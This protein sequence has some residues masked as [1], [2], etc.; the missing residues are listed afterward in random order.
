MS[1][2]LQCICCWWENKLRF[3]GGCG[4]KLQAILAPETAAEIFLYKLLFSLSCPLGSPRC[5]RDTDAEQG[6]HFSLR[7]TTQLILDCCIE[8][9]QF[10]SISPRFVCFTRLM[11]CTQT[12]VGRYTDLHGFYPFSAVPPS[13]LV[14]KVPPP[15]PR[16]FKF[17]QVLSSRFTNLPPGTAALASDSLTLYVEQFQS[18]ATAMSLLSVIRLNSEEEDNSKLFCTAEFR[19]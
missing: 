14:Q 1:T 7:L 12:N 17:Q 13:M 5:L 19:Y 2:T 6:C 8:Q 18:G 4:I 16:S 11:W 9:T 15:F 10:D 3:D